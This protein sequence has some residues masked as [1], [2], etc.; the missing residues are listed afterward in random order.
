MAGV[1]TVAVEGAEEEVEVEVVFASWASIASVP[2]LKARPVLPKVKLAEQQF[3]LEEEQQYKSWTSPAAHGTMGAKVPYVVSV[4]GSGLHQITRAA[5]NYFNR[6]D[7][8]ERTGVAS[9]CAYR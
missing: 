4:R 3:P 2:F 6:I 1:V 8:S 9:L 7:P 5:S